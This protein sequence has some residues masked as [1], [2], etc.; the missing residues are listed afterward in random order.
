MRLWLRTASWLVPTSWASGKLGHVRRT[1]VRAGW[2]TALCG[3]LIALGET[4]AGAQT[5]VVN[6]SPTAGDSILKTIMPAL[7]GMIGVI[8]GAALTA[9]GTR[10]VV[11][12]QVQIKNV[13]EERAKWRER[14]RKLAAELEKA[15]RTNDSCRLAV[16]HTSMKLSLNP[17]DARDQEIVE[18][19]REAS[20]KREGR[21][22]KVDKAVALLA[23]VLKHDWQRAK[24]EARSGTWQER[25]AW[26][27]AEWRRKRAS[28]CNSCLAQLEA[29][30]DR[31]ARACDCPETTGC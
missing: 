19:V 29:S 6:V 5:T 11:D 1:A 17:D 21:L 22:E 9:W 8:F 26:Q 28:R 18:L 31:E 4:A 15:A 13:T 7:I 30:S 16:I 23:R 14:I 27:C 20:E 2:S 3:G 25:H 12:R 24:V 10:Y